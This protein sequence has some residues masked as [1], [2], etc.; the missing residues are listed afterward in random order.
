MLK[1]KYNSIIITGPTASGKTKLAALTAFH[2]NGEIISAD[3]RQVYQK[4]DIGTGKDLSEYEI[5]GNKINHHLI[6][7]QP[8]ESHFNLYDFV[9]HFY[10]AFTKIEAKNK[11]PIVCGGTGLYLD[12]VIKKLHLTAIP[13]DF[14]LRNQLKLCNKDELI[15]KLNT[16]PNQN[17]KVD[18]SSSKRMI[19]AI[20]IANFLSKNEAPKVQFADLKPIIFVLNM[21][22]SLRQTNITNRLKLRLEN[23]MIDEVK[24]L[25]EQGITHERLQFLGL[26]YLFVSKYLLNEISYETLF[27]KLETAIHQYAKRQMTWFRKMEREGNKMYWLDATKSVEENM[28]II[29]NVE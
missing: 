26:E 22:V 7:I 12:A 20:E 6:D 27:T 19:R 13:N 1:E 5:N 3:S 25:I 11:L 21:S 16:Y 8:I 29:R 15:E 10:D 24:N 2:L 17:E 4:L 14:E 28:E 23:G 18:L 9:T